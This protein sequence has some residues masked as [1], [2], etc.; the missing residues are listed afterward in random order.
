MSRTWVLALIGTSAIASAAFASDTPATSAQTTAAGQAA[1]TKASGAHTT[2]VRKI[3]TV[4]DKGGSVVNPTIK[5][6]VIVGRS[7]T[8]RAADED[9]GGGG[10]T[11]SE[12]NVPMDPGQTPQEPTVPPDPGQN[13]QEQL[14]QQRDP[15]A[16]E[17]PKPNPPHNS[18]TAGTAAVVRTNSAVRAG[19]AAATSSSAVGRAADGDGIGPKQDDPVTPRPGTSSVLRSSTVTKAQTGKAATVNATE[20]AH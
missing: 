1:K 20:Q 17:P 13:P 6:G 4:N 14:P 16:Q 2:G 9:G 8:G 19:R 12:P 18:L 5:T 15:H 3:S 10:Q 11:P 7:G